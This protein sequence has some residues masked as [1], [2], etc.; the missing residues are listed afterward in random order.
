VGAG[1]AL[2]HLATHLGLR[3]SDSSPRQL[4]KLSES[5]DLEERA[6]LQNDQLLVSQVDEGSSLV[7]V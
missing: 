2:D 7:L 5:D 3:S 4:L 1:R 6:V